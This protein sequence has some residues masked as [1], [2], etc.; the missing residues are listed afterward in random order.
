MK[1]KSSQWKFIVVYDDNKKEIKKFE[2][3]SDGKLKEKMKRLKK[4]SLSRSINITLPEETKETNK[5]KLHITTNTIFSYFE[6][7]MPPNEIFIEYPNSL[8]ENFN[9]DKSIVIQH[10]SKNDKRKKKR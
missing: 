5:K 10:M 2:L 4:R 6:D 7:I 9:S 1:K 3:E 8:V